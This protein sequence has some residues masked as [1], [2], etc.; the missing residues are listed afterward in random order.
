MSDRSDG[1]YTY[2]RSHS[3]S[4][5]QS[6]SHS[7]SHSRDLAYRT[8]NEEKSSK[9]AKKLLDSPGSKDGAGS[10]RSAARGQSRTIER[11]RD[12]VKPKDKWAGVA[13]PHPVCFSSSLGPAQI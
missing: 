5:S 10:S 4:L 3:R 13:A 8:A 1:S 7:H 6:Y 2:S 11:E 12:V 9:P